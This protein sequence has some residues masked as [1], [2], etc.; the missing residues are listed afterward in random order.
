MQVHGSESDIDAL[1]IG[2]FFA[3]MAVSLPFW[4]NDLNDFSVFFFPESFR[5]LSHWLQEDFFIVLRNMLKSRLE[6]SEVLCVKDAKVPLIRFKFD[7]ILVDLPYA[8]LRVLSIPNVRF[9]QLS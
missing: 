3:S 2:P 6:V 5:L 8:Q 9:S 7:G 4:L 1:C